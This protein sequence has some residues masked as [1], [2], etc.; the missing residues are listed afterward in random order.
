MK[1]RGIAMILNFKAKAKEI[2]TNYFEDYG[3][4]DYSESY[5]GF[6]IHPDKVIRDL[7]GLGI[8]FY[9]LLDVGCASGELV[10][11]FRSLGIRAYG[12]DNNEEIID[13]SVVPQ[14]CAKMDMRNLQIKPN[15]FDI[16]Y[17]NSLMY[18]YPQEV[19]PVLKSFHTIVKKAVYLCVPFSE[20][21]FFEDPYRKFVGKRAWWRKQ[22]LE[23]GFKR[24]SDQIYLK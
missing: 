24:A 23:A 14:F 16:I 3:G 10:R 18:L 4:E 5:L 19:L 6:T 12:V 13:R 15:T 2:D 20:D 7:M 8:D 1:I 17:A 22:F 11:D 9:T 21:S